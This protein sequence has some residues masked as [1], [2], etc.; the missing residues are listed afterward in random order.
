MVTW[1]LWQN[2]NS[3]VWNEVKNTAN[4]VAL[5]AVHMYEEWLSINEVQQQ[6]SNTVSVSAQIRR[7]A[8]A[9]SNSQ[10]IQHVTAQIRWQKPCA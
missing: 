3:W 5:R 1:C 4:E 7:A 10:A 8:T 6:N 9:E 2:R